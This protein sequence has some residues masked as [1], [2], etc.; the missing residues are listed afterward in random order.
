QL[1]SHAI[2]AISVP[3]FDRRRLYVVDRDRRLHTIESRL[4]SSTSTT[5]P[6]ILFLS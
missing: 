5:L 6:Q 4:S 3:K 2:V 1:R